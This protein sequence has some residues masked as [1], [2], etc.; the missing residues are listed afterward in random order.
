MSILILFTTMWLYDKD[1]GMLSSY[2]RKDITGP[3]KKLL[4]VVFKI[5]PSLTF[6]REVKARQTDAKQKTLVVGIGG[7]SGRNP[8]GPVAGQG[9]FSRRVAFIHRAR[10]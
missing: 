1:R 10:R 9:R 3:R 5:W 4:D 7:G 8:V 2:E 6:V